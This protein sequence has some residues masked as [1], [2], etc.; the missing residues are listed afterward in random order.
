MSD[1][2][3]PVEI[4]TLTFPALRLHPRDA[5]KLRGYFAK[6][7]G[8]DSV[9]FHNHTEGEGFRYGYSLVQYK[10]IK[11]VP[12]VVGVAEGARLVLHTFIDLQEI[13]L[14]GQL[15]RVDDK[16]L[17]VNKTPAGVI[18]ELRE[19]R[20]AS[21]LFAFNQDN[22]AAFKNMP[23]AEHKA[24]LTKLITS[25]LITALRGIGCEVTEER[26]IMLSHRLEPRLVNYKNQRMQMYVGGFTANVALPE[27]L[28][29]GKSTS[30]GFGT[31]V[32]G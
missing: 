7:F 27:G 4:T 22:Y 18:S 5:G 13:D 24:F 14:E 31:V 2:T 17:E 23:A 20:F 9:L 6:A 8:K 15:V 11:G 32:A 3:T 28:G 16:E 30:K 26:P 12:T 21:P 19:Y 25:H 1:H 29:V 10:V